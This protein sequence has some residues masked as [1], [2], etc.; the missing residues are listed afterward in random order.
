MKN[1]INKKKII[2]YA[3]AGLLTTVITTGV[4]F[5][6]YDFTIDHTQELC[7]LTNFLGDGHQYAAMKRDYYVQGIPA[8][9]GYTHKLVSEVDGNVIDATPIAPTIEN[10][11]GILSYSLPE[12]YY[13]TRDCDGELCGLPIGTKIE[14]FVVGVHEE[15]ND[16]DIVALSEPWEGEFTGGRTIYPKGV[17]TYGEFFKTTTPEGEIVE[18]YRV[19]DAVNNIYNIYDVQPREY[20]DEEIETINAA[21]KGLIR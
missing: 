11:N 15:E 18:K 20:S 7:P 4:G 12:G 6:I 3:A 5:E 9:V 17:S 1:K 14:H 19:Y 10:S 16:I 8:V 21:R 13:L 2:K